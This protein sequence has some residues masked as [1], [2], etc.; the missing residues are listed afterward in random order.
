MEDNVHTTDD[1]NVFTT[2][3]DINEFNNTNSSDIY[4]YSVCPST[5]P[6]FINFTDDSNISANNSSSILKTRAKLIDMKH[7]KTI[8]DYD[9]MDK[10]KATT[11]LLTTRNMMTIVY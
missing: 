6:F 7:I 5:S 2:D 10:I 4:P 8:A 9:V 3:D 11:T 1:D